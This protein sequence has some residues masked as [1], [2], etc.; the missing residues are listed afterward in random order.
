[1]SAIIE[2][3]WKLKSFELAKANGEIEYPFGQD[4]MGY[5]IYS[6]TGHFSVQYMAKEQLGKSPKGISYFGHY[7]YN[8]EKNYVVHH[9]ECS[10]FPNEEGLDKIRHASLRGKGL[11]LTCPPLKWDGD[12]DDSVVTISFEKQ[13]DIPSV[14]FRESSVH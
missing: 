7:E 11:K 14:E 8:R 1:M 13:E 2:G 4:A 6:P 10:L 9:V 3:T 12:D 5:I